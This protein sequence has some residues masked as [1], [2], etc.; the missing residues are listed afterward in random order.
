MSRGD[1]REDIFLDDVDRHEWLKT[2]AE[3][4]QKTAWQIHAYCLMRNHFHLVIETPAGSLVAGMAWMLTKLQRMEGKFGDHHSGK[5]ERE[6][7]VAKGERIVVEELGR[8]GWSEGELL[9]RRKGD[10]EKM[11]IAKRLRKETTL[12]IKS[13]A[14]RLHLGT[15]KSAN[16]RLHQWMNALDTPP[17][18]AASK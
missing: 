2:L 11:A 13:I 18:Q 12:P 6:S 14:A 10:P 8:L 17:A 7:A 9:A 4:C 3:T 16:A 15:S 5:L 1:R